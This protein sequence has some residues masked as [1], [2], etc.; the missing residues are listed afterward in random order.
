MINVTKYRQMTLL[1]VGQY[2]LHLYHDQGAGRPGRNQLRKLAEFMSTSCFG[3]EAVRRAVRT[4]GLTTGNSV[5]LCKVGDSSVVSKE[6]G[7]PDSWS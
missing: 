6:L 5:L 4:L 3:Y 2:S 1:T 7:Q